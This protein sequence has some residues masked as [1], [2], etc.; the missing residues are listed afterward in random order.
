FYCAC[1][2]VPFALMNIHFLYRY[3]VVRYPHLVSL[4]TK[5]PFVLLLCLICIAEWILWYY[6]CIFGLTGEKDEIGTQLLREEYQKKYGK[7]IEDGWLVMDH[8][9]DDYFDGHVFVVQAL[10][11]VVIA[12]SF[13]FSST[14][15][16]LT[17]YHIKQSEKFS[18]Q[19]QNLQL[20]LF[21]AVT[22]QTVIPLIFVYIPYF[23]CLNF[24][25]LGLPVVQRGAFCSLLI[26]CFPAWGAVIVLVL[27]PDYQRGISGIV[28]RQ[29]RS[30]YKM[31]NVIIRT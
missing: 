10:F 27:M 16:C 15:A 24:P 9:K 20:K 3:W 8:W 21:I 31:D 17:F 30:A 14:L 5:L 12:T 28:K 19:A 4:F 13:I 18:V 23:C 11:D 6:L 2:A 1:F 7:W 25:F 22:A 26:A 29:F